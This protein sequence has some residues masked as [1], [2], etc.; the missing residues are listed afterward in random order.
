MTDEII[1]K[2]KIKDIFSINIFGRRFVF[3]NKN[4]CKMKINDEIQQLDYSYINKSYYKDNS[5]EYLIV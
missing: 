3:K 2:Y 5:L 1:M 4:N